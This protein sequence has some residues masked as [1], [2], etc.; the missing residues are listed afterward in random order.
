MCEVV[1]SLLTTPL[2]GLIDVVEDELRHLIKFEAI[3]NPL[4]API[5]A[6]GRFLEIKILG[7]KIVCFIGSLI[8]LRQCMTC[9]WGCAFLAP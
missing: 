7:F 5:I 2:N 9:F 8:D 1:I 3:E 6:I 4:L